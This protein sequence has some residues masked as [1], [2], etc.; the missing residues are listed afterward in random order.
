MD[1]REVGYDDRDWIN[2]AQDRDR[3]RAYMPKDPADAENS[4]DGLRLK[5]TL[6]AINH[7]TATFGERL[8]PHG[9]LIAWPP[10]SPDLTSCEF[11]IWGSMKDMVY[12]TP[13]EDEHTLSQPIMAAAE[14][15]Q[16]TPRIFQRSRERRHFVS[17]Q[18]FSADALLLSQELSIAQR[19]AEV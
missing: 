18:K 17:W 16:T 3:W 4:C 15:I 6:S 12:S 13:I 19:G 11:F 10:R 5:K 8:I 9:G 14:V 2:L 1:L 7:L